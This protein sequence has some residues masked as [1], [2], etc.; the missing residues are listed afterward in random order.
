M[1]SLSVLVAAVVAVSIGSAAHSTD[2]TRRIPV[3]EDFGEVTIRFGGFANGISMRVN[4]IAPTGV[5]ELCGA[6]VFTNAQLESSARSFL[7]DSYFVVNGERA[8][9]GLHYFKRVSRTKDLVGSAANCASLGVPAA[10]NMDFDFEWSKR[11]YS[12]G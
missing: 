11:S 10:P 4:I 5:L 2:L 7:R 8:I 6:V 12:T 9:R 3:T 1:K